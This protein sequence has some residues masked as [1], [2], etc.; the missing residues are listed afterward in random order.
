M[1]SAALLARAF[2]RLPCAS[3]ALGASLGLGWL[4]DGLVVFDISFLLSA[5]ATTGL[6]LLGEPLR[7]P[8]EQLNSR[9]GR[10]LGG[11]I[12][13]TLAAMIPCAPLLA[14]L[15]SDI[16]LAGILANVLAAPL[17]EAVALPL[18]LVHMFTA[19]LRELESGIALVASGALLVVR[20][21][22]RESAAQRWLAVP[23]PDPT[24]YHLALFAAVVGKLVLARGGERTAFW[25]RWWLLSGGLGLLVVELAVRRAGAPHGVLRMTALSV[26]QGDST[27]IDLPDGKLMLI[28][29]GGAP[30]GGADPGARVVLPTLRARR[31]ARLDVVVLTHPHPDH[32]GGLVSVLRNVEVGEL[33]DSGQGALEGAGPVYAELLKI[34]AERGVRV[35]GPKELCGAP[36]R[37]G[38]GVVSLLAPCPGIV[39]GRN[40]NDNSLV[41]KAR[42]GERAFLF[43]GDAEMEE[44]R[45]LVSAYGS[46]L[47]ANV[48]KVGHH[49]SRTS[50][51]EPLL[52]AVAP[53]LAT[54]SCGVRNRFGHPVPMVMQRIESHGTHALRTDRDGAI[55]ISNDGSALNWAVAYAR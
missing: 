28:D 10:W 21:I 26:G 7:R 36:R 51:S 14:L 42:L 41:L 40:A 11:A 46:E 29:G 44:E 3:R 18:C 52:A 19:P 13:T 48:L 47:R 30:D 22:A 20:A 33:W 15:G 2:G 1:L 27:L 50:S 49:G 45:E 6:L 16:T 34:A 12:A 23:V 35:L 32:F 25:L 55:Q 17:G 31:R 24:A 43:M 38:D 8:C 39:R 9:V 53:E 5:A 54:V 4:V 37:F